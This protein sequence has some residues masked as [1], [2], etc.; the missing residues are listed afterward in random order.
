MVAGPPGVKTLLIEPFGIET[1][2]FPVIFH[3]SGG[4]LIE[5]FGIETP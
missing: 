2:E 1:P 5:P 3:A 4:L